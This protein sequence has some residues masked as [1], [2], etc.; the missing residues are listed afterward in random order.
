MNILYT[1]V[2]NLGIEIQILGF[3]LYVNMDGMVCGV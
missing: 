1:T 3:F 2:Q